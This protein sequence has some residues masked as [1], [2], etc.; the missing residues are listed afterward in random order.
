MNEDERYCDKEI[1]QEEEI[2]SCCFVFM[3]SFVM[4]RRPPR[5]CVIG[6][7]QDSDN[8]PGRLTNCI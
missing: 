6:D 4:A 3:S 5:Y 7:A 1:D 8:F 2:R